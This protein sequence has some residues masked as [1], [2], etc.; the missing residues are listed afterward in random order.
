MLWFK[1]TTPARTK[2]QE[3][4]DNAKAQLDIHDAES[5]DY[6]KVLTNIERLTTLQS[7]EKKTGFHV[8]A[9]TWVAAGASLAGIL[10]IVVYEHA[11]AFT[12]KAVTFVPK[13]KI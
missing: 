5:A 10:I 1:K 8:S 6:L 7:L 9:D 2:T 13:V 3:L 11:H 12:S 4:I